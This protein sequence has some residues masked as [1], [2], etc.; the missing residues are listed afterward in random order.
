MGTK[1]MCHPSKTKT[2]GG[3]EAEILWE[4]YILKT[5]SILVS[6]NFKY[7]NNVVLGTFLQQLNQGGRRITVRLE[8]L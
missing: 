5:G 8:K 3:V 7:Y 4:M 2:H 1:F 6:F